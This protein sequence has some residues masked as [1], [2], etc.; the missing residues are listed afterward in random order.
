MDDMDSIAQ[1]DDILSQMID[2]LDAG[3]HPE[4]WPEP[5]CQIFAQA[6]VPT[7]RS[8]ERGLRPT[9]T[10]EHAKGLRLSGWIWPGKSTFERV[11]DWV[12]QRARARDPNLEVLAEHVRGH[13]VHI[14]IQR[15]STERGAHAHS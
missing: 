5:L 6:C 2:L 1:R 9:P 3:Q 4:S 8:L 12:T 13:L 7:P 14:L 15:I 11:P 10:L